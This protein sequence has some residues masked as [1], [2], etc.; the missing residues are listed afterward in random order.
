MCSVV[1]AASANPAL[2]TIARRYP[3]AT[4]KGFFSAARRA[5][6]HDSCIAFQGGWWRRHMN[7]SF[8]ISR[9]F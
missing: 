5:K 9:L 3:S 4:F 8:S 7:F 1:Q 2:L 6:F